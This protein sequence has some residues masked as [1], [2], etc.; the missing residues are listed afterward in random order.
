VANLGWAAH[1]VG[2]DLRALHA[3]QLESKLALMSEKLAWFEQQGAK[4]PAS[5]P[6]PA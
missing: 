2:L 1:Q 3:R 6:G 4:P 5:S